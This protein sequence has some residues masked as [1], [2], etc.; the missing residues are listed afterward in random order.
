MTDTDLETVLHLSR[1]GKGGLVSSMGRLGIDPTPVLPKNGR[2]NASERLALISAGVF[3]GAPTPA[4]KLPLKPGPVAPRSVLRRSRPR[5]AASVRSPAPYARLQVRPTR[6]TL[7]PR[8]LV[9]QRRHQS[10]QL[11]HLLPLLDESPLVRRAI[12][13][14]D[15][16]APVCPKRIRLVPLWESYSHTDATGFAPLTKHV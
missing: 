13:S 9:T 2:A 14:Q 10:L 16:R 3:F 5:H 15:R 7:E 8:N 6:T 1:G 12:G 4:Q 11:D